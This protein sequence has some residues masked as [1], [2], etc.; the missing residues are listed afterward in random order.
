MIYSKI[1]RLTACKI[2]VLSTFL[3]TACSEEPGNTPLAHD[4][5][6]TEE[7]ALLENINVVA[8]ARQFQTIAEDST[9]TKL[10]SSIVPG[11]IIR[12]SELDSV[13]FDTTGL[14]YYSRTKNSSGEFEFNNISLKS[15]Y[16]ML[17]LSP[18]NECETDKWI[19]RCYTP[20][21]KSLIYSLIVDLRKSKNVG[22]NVATTIETKRLLK[23]ISEGMSF[24]DANQ[25]A[26]SD[27]LKAFGIYNV[28]YRF[29]KAISDENRAEILL[30]DN[31][32]G[33]FSY[34]HARS[35]QGAADEFAKAGTFNE[36]EVTRQ[37]LI[38][39]V[40]SWS[41]SSQIDEEEK[42]YLHDYMHN[43]MASL[44]GFGQCTADYEGYS[45]T[46]P[47][48][49][50]KDI[51]FACLSGAWS[52]LIHYAVP[53]SVGAV[54]GQMTDSRDGTKYNTVTYNIDGES[55]TWLAENLK[56]NSTDGI[57]FWNEA[58][59]LPDSI[60]LIPYESCIEEKSYTYCDRLQAQKSNLDYEKIWAITDSVKAAG[61]T[62]Q[63]ICPDGW[64]LP[65]LH[66]WKKLR[67][68]VTE[69]ID[70]GSL[71]N[72]DVMAIAG[73]G[74]SDEDYGTAY[75]VKIDSTIQ[76]ST[77][78]GSSNSAIFS[79][80]VEGIEWS[81]VSLEGTVFYPAPTKKNSLSVRCIKD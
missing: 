63:G 75:A 44:F 20:Y 22:I 42:T 7:Q 71:T 80:F 57:Y 9:T 41:H 81:Y 11:S 52:F 45:T 53:D 23:L 64:H 18:S 46:L 65:D 69:K 30:T 58:M 76:L 43:F 21:Q 62:Y 34:I 24:E 73:F 10:V 5:G 50:H 48:E 70:I 54:L 67:D 27:L 38:G 13:T 12:M 61:K 36:A 29:D 37:F 47:Y 72:E 32:S 17:E 49:A 4:G 56:Y 78:Q 3:F 2:A 28:P 19:E 15:P 66:E 1:S 79:V 59:N 26:E 77:H 8:Y 51:D 25:Q 35:L 68:Y 55:Q 39:F 16:V 33:W 60:A 31:L 40:E 74:E 6:Y 14:V